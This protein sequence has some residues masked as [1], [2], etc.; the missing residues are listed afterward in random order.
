[1][2]V[3][4]AEVPEMHDRRLGTASATARS[5]NTLTKGEL[6]AVT[7]GYSSLTLTS[8]SCGNSISASTN[9]SSATTMLMFA[10][11]ANQQQQHRPTVVAGNGVV[12]A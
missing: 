10:L 2:T 9:N 11:L 12:V 4:L 7:G 3:C 6:D 8:S 5:M 1:L